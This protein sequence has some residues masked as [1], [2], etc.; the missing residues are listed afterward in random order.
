MIERVY[1]QVEK[2]RKFSEII[3]A[4]DDKRIENVVKGFGGHAVMTSSDHQSGTDRIWEVV[5]GKSIDGVINIQGDEPLVSDQLISELY[6]LLNTGKYDVVTAANYNSSYD[7]FLSNHINKVV[8]TRDSRALYFSRSPIPFMAESSFSGFYQH[9]GIYGY[10]KKALETFVCLQHSPLEKLERLEQL[11][12][13][14]NNISIQ[15]LQTP[16]KSIGVD[17]PGDITEVEKILRGD[18]E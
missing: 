6:D 3:V 8:L 11:R 1:R 4:T 18:H 16:Y 5:R 13:I 14:E 7:D 15:V 17:L 10:Q 2:S 12:F 9:I